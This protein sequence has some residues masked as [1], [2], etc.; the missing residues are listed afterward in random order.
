MIILIKIGWIAL[1]VVA[2]VFG[3]FLTMVIHFCDSMW[4]TIQ[5]LIIKIFG[6]CI[7]LGGITLI[8]NVVIA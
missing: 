7:I 2:I 4:H 3:A 6:L 1:A 5:C 8:Y